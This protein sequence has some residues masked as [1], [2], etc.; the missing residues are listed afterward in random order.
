MSSTKFR[1]SA[2]ALVA[3]AMGMTFAATHSRAEGVASAWVDGFNNKARL[4]AG[5][6]SSPMVKNPE[7]YGAIEIAMPSG[8]KT[9]WRSPGDAGGIPPEFDFNGSQN[10]EGFLVYYPAPHRL[11][12]KAGATIGYKDH[13]IFPV[14]VKAKD[15]SQPIIL[16]LK[17]A[18]GVCKELCVPAEAEI[19]L[20]IPPDVGKS[21]VIQSAMSSLPRQT[22]QAD[23]DP[24]LSAWRVDARDGKPVLVLDVTDPGGT[25]GDAFADAPGGAYLPVSK[26]VA[27]DGA[28]ATYE[29]DLSDGVD[30]KELKAKPIT[31]TLV[32]PKGQSQSS[33]V[34]P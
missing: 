14:Q 12:D 3:A 28:R 5:Q 29:I 4:L 15:P 8:W 17:A 31:I 26:K 21:D 7:L 22:P 27:E 16:K 9:Y 33:I 1:N 18:Y 2:L 13:V 34:L 10:A 32:G 11:I 23:S 19:E 6:V 25:G 24:V 20:T 30:L